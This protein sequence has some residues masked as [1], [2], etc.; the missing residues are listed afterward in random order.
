MAQRAGARLQGDWEGCHSTC[1]DANTSSDAGDRVLSNQFTKS[2]YPLGIMVNAN[3]DRFVDEGHDFRNFTY[4]K[5]GR[6]I[7]KQPGGYAFQIYDSKII[8]WLRKE[9]YGDGIVEKIWGDTIEELAATLAG[10]GLE[11]K[12]NFVKTVRQFNH[13]AED[14]SAG[15]PQLKWDPAVK[16]GL[17]TTSLPLPKSNWALSLDKAPFLAVKV[18]TGITF[19][20]GGLAIDSETAGVLSEETGKPIKGLF[21]TGEMVG[22]LFYS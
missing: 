16:D 4:A 5:F 15:N 6:E 19:T 2:G 1:W 10:K 3:G 9:E 20:F 17:S 22:G 12:E 8:P 14:F 7:M 21:C 13:A 18:A 11:D